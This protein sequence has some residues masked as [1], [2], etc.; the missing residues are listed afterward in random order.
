[1]D[2]VRLAADGADVSHV[3]RLVLA[4][5]AAVEG[6]QRVDVAHTGAHVLRLMQSPTGVVYVS[7][8]GFIAGEVGTTIITPELVAI[9]HGWFATDR[10][11]L[12]LLSAF[13]I[14][15]ASMGCK[16]IK[17]STGPTHAA[18]ARILERRGYRP[19]ELAWYR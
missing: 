6:P 12:R 18:A 13:E 9:E 4:L 19:A 10:S 17:M 3:V 14:W 11:G 1:M 7:P 2:R 16:G 5:T 15:A 8:G